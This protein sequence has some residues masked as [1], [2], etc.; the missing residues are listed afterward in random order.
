M[1]TMSC[2]VC[3]DAILEGGIKVSTNGLDRLVCCTECAE[4][5]R[6]SLN[7]PEQAKPDQLPDYMSIAQRCASNRSRSDLS[8][9]NQNFLRRFEDFWSAP[10]GARI[11]ELFSPEALIHFAGYGTVSGETYVELM[12]SMLG[13]VDSI[14]VTVIDYAERDDRLFIF[15]HATQLQNGKQLSWHGVDRFRIEAGMA[16]EEQV[17]FDTKVFNS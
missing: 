4:T 9:A 6:Q 15:W 10:S 2:S 14:A 12:D 3:G 13:G 5:C 11:R 16:I 7:T 17:I 8:E 1:N